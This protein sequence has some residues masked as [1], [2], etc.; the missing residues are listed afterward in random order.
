M[1]KY[2]M[3]QH[4]N[5]AVRASMA[6]HAVTVPIGPNFESHPPAQFEY[7][8]KQGYGLHMSH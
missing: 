4:S 2:T 7:E 8:G 1:Y 5:L 6:P 3:A